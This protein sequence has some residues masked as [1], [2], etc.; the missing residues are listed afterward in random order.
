MI[1]SIDPESPR[2]TADLVLLHGAWSGPPI[3]GRIA[4]AMA[5]RGWRC[6]LVDLRAAA[7]EVRG[8]AG[9]GWAAGARAVVA[10]LEAPPIVVGH[11]AGG[12][13]ALELA[14]A[15]GLRAAIAAAPLA[16][17]PRPL[18]PILERWRLRLLR[19]T[20]QPPGS[21]HPVFAGLAS[22]DATRLAA[23]LVA[24]VAA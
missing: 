6:H 3:W 23:S 16:E 22:E 17:G 10:T 12:L 8:D 14:T 21:D 18:A 13:V 9:A 4:A 1:D 20:L 7:S 19:G 15:P 2:Y 5:Q 11:G 24:E